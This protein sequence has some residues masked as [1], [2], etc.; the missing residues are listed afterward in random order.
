MYEA[1]AYVKRL[2]RMKRGAPKQQFVHY[3]ASVKEGLLATM[4]LRRPGSRL[5]GCSMGCGYI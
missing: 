2:S 4:L 5:T 1:L 3:A